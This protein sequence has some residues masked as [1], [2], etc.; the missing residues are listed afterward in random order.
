MLY[1]HKDI[2]D[3]IYILYWF[4]IFELLENWENITFSK[5]YK[6]SF[7]NCQFIF[8]H[9]MFKWTEFPIKKF[10]FFMLFHWFNFQAFPRTFK[11]PKKKAS[12]FHNNK[13]LNS[14]LIMPILDILTYLFWVN[15]L[16]HL[17]YY[18][19]CFTLNNNNNKKYK[20]LILFILILT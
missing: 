11:S 2:V 10:H 6:T 19:Y 15:L 4:Q 16:N 9:Q 7:R 13:M 14:P 3:Q 17:N 18:G 1:H 12:I 5:Q 8:Q 20:D